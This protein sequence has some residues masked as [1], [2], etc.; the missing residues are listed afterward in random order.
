MSE[1]RQEWTA[2]LK[3]RARVDEATG[4]REAAVESYEQLYGRAGDG[5]RQVPWMADT[6]DRLARL[7]EAEASR[8]ES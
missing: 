8:G 4:N 6:E 7:K 3:E 1:R 5:L 2:Q